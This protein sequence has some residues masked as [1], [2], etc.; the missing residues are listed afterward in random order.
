VQKSKDNTT[1]EKIKVML[2][3]FKIPTEQ[4]SI[5]TAYINK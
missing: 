3:D 4:I 1:F 2:I 5:K